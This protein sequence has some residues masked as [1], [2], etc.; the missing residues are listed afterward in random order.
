MY[1]LVDSFFSLKRI[2]KK[3]LPEIMEYIQGIQVS[4]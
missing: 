3:F 1:T 2:F 4:L